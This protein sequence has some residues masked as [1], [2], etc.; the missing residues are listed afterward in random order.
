M[1]RI[2]TNFSQGTR[3]TI[4][5]NRG[6]VQHQSIANAKRPMLAEMSVTRHTPMQGRSIQTQTL[7]MLCQL[8]RGIQAH[9][10]RRHGGTDAIFQRKTQQRLVKA[11]HTL[12]SAHQTPD[13][14]LTCLKTVICS[15][16]TLT[17]LVDIQTMDTELF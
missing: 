5:L 6:H 12:P 7:A 15:L 3:I 9:P 10:T 4:H 14:V 11:P 13:S 16:I 8:N 17:F 2:L 1:R